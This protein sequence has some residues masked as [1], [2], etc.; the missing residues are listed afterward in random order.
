VSKWI[1][2]AALAAMVVFGG[3]TADA[4]IT[5]VI[6]TPKRN[7]A[8]QQQ[9]VARREEAAQDSITRVT[10]TGMKEWV[11]S[12]AAALALRP[13]TGT[14]PAGDS[15]ASSRAASTQAAASRADSAAPSP[16]RQATQ[17]PEFRDGARAPDTGTPVPTIALIG[18]IMI[19]IGA[20][21]R[22]LPAA[23]KARVPK[24]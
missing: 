18:A 16:N 15:A 21:L 3:A 5:T 17:T 20:A 11:D 1:G 8:K 24:R 10:M 9:A 22:R 13:D 6:E 12:A 14:V 2:R 23:A 4:Q 19:L 7:E